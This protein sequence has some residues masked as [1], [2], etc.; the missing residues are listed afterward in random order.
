VDETAGEVLLYGDQVATTLFSSS[1]GGRTQSSADAFGP[2]GRPYLVSRS[3]PYDKISPYHDWGP[4]PVTGKTL[5]R[6][7]GISGRIVDAT[8][9][10]NASRRVKT[11]KLTSLLRGTQSTSSVTGAAVRSAAGL[12]STWFSL[13]VLSLVPPFPNARVT[14][15]T[16]VRLTGVVRGVHG[17]VVQ[18]RV[19]GKPWMQLRTVV[20]APRTGA[21]H[22]S[23]RPKVTT[24]YRLATAQDA[25]AFV[26]IRVLAVSGSDATVK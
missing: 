23:V 5:G 3:D 26:R 24:D 11:L 2:P 13:A 22:F 25:A 9:R 18:E 4:M 10:R 6:A 21:F 12:R 19:R 15:G 20:P 7:F 14:S 17:V 8:V 16:R 1:T